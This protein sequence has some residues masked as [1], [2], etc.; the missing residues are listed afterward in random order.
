M[1]EGV[2]ERFDE[3]ARHVIVRARAEALALNHDWV[4]SEHELIG[5]LADPDPA[6]VPRKALSAFGVTAE[7]ARQQLVAM[8][9]VGDQPVGE[10][11]LNP[12]AKRVIE[13]ALR[14]SIELGARTIAPEHL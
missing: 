7:L 12:R 9:G 3:S 8:V 13:L 4:G 14:E 11:R 5:L 6:A 10:I 1:I 2:F